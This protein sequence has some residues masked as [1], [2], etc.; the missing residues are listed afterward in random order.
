MKLNLNMKSGIILIILF[1]QVQFIHS[2]TQEKPNIIIIMTDQQFADAMSCVMGSQYIHT[3]N[4]D[5]LAE[6]GIRFTRAY[7]PNPLCM[8]M[9]TSMMTGSFPHQNGVLTNGNDDISP[10]NF[11]F[12]GKL[13][14]DAGYETGYFGK[15]HVAF[16]INKKDIHGFDVLFPKSNLDSEPAGEFIKQKHDKP[17]FAV[18]SF[19]SPHEVCQWARKQELPGGPIAELPPLEDLPPLKINFFAPENET[20]IMTF[21][22]KSYQANLRLFPLADYT[23]A[24]WRRLQWG[25]Y[26]LIERADNFLGEVMTAL[27]E[28]GQE[29]NTL[30]VFLSDHGDCAGSHHWNQKTVFYD[31]S[32][33]VPFILKWDG[34]TTT[35]TSDVLLNTG[36]DMIPTLC[37]F[38][39]IEIPAGLPGKSLM[40][41]ATGKIPDWKRDFVV[42]ENHMVQ[43]EPVDG[44]N[45]QPQGR[46]IRSDRYK[47]CIYS[48][49]DDKESL[50]DMQFDPLEMVNQ[51]RNPVYEKVL[52][53]HREYLKQHAAQ[54]NDE[55]AMQMLTELKN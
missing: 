20:D 5:K 16:D 45:Y 14:K 48:E 4:M 31:E 41:A 53:Q 6:K 25:Y 11:V 33:R 17:F 13:F 9:R 22:R 55:M 28:S 42:T 35:G 23:N 50:V 10:S 29:E 32:S 21:M 39:G 52:E 43:N 38:A 1:L 37:D 12:M 51:A 26:R 19:L 8:P 54:T 36:T 44:K 15:W 40:A 47:Y 46:M 34:K 27:K 18:A 3:P 49:G 7:S 24:D 30:V 2:Q